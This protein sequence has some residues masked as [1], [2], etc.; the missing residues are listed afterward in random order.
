MRRLHA[1]VRGRVQGV[2]FRATTRYEAQKLGL[3]GWVRNRT[4]G[5][6]EVDAE[7]DEQRLE[8]FLAYLRQG[9]LGA[10]VDAVEADWGDGAGAPASF[11]IRRTT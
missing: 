5:T 7:G 4:D 1:T 6:V 11:E 10:H 9:P 3:S 8:A 2:G